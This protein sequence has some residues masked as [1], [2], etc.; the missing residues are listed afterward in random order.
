MKGRKFNG[1]ATVL[2]PYLRVANVQ[3]GF[4]DLRE[5]KEIEVLRLILKDTSSSPGMF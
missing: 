4:I 2:M 5:I 1:Q 3:D